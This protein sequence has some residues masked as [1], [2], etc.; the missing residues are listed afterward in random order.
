[1]IPP[2]IIVG[3]NLAANKMLDIKELVV[4]FPCDPAITIFFFNEIMLANHFTTFVYMYFFF[5]A[6]KYST[7]FFLIAEE[8]TSMVTFLIFFF[9]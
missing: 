2:L 1:M 6:N 9:L 4:V 8:I 5:L 3:S 7:L